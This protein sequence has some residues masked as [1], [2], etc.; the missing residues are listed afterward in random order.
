MLDIQTKTDIELFVNTFY[1][2]VLTNKLLAPF[3]IHLDF[4]KHLPKM[5]HFWSFV[6]LD[7]PGYSTNVTDKHMNIPLKKEHFETW[8]T[9]FHETLDELFKGEKVESAKQHAAI[10]G[11]TIESK[12]K[13]SH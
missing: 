5:I 12:M 11:W 7:E 4:E 3:F 1:N 10:I 13:T 6:L 9:L 2:K 8:L